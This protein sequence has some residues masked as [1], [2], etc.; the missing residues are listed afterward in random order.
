VTSDDNVPRR[1]A[2]VAARQGGGQRAGAREAGSA[3]CL[4]RRG[5]GWGGRQRAASIVAGHGPDQHAGVVDGGWGEDAG[6]TERGR[7]GVGGRTMMHRVWMP[8]LQSYR[9]IEISVVHY[10]LAKN[11]SPSSKNKHE[12]FTHLVAVPRNADLSK[13]LLQLQLAK[14]NC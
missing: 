5:R 4:S 9:V 2:S 7:E 10:V 6:P 11:R 13:F 12:A 14:F 1:G 8:T 3:R